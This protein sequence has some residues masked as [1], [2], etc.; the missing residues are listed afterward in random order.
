MNKRITKANPVGWFEIYVD[1]L[2]RA[3]KFY[4]TV[5]AT[6][7]EQLPSPQAELKMMAFPMEMEA[8]GAAGALCRM[9]GVKPGGGGTLVYFKCEDCGT[10]ASRVEAAGGQIQQ[11]K[12]P[13]G[14]YGFMVLAVDPEGN[15]FGLHSQT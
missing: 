14:E 10:E 11:A 1:D 13:I 2:G 8:A 12:T 9:E 3:A 7:L 6:K 5:L 15:M 4:E